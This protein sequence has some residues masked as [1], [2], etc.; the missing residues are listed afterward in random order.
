M[1]HIEEAT[2]YI[3]A[4]EVAKILKIQIKTFRKYVGMIDKQSKSGLYF[5]R[6]EK[7]HR[8]YTQSDVDLLKQL[9]ALKDRP[10]MTIESAIEQLINMDYSPSTNEATEKH[11]SYGISIDVLQKFISKQ[12]EI[13][14]IKNT[15]LDKYEELLND[16][17]NQNENLQ[18]EVK[19]LINNQKQFQLDQDKK[20]EKI[21]EN[22]IQTIIEE[23]MTG[24]KLKKKGFFSKLF[25]K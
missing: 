5:E 1:K 7:N 10:K 14:E 15:Q 4:D 9:I 24:D 12:N 6:D 18:N 3:H 11:G 19:E 20:T 25:N 17:A 8:L 23:P 13:I 16:F 21:N 2:E 22:S